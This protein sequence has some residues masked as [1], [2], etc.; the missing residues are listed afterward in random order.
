MT[1]VRRLRVG[2]S[3]AS[4]TG[5][6]VSTFYT[7]G[8]GAALNSAVNV[9]F[10]AIKS[11]FPTVT[12]WT[13]PTSGEELD[14]NTGNVTGVWTGGTPATL[15]GSG[16]PEHAQGVGGRIVW[17][18]GGITGGRLVRGSTF[19]VP[20]C[21]NQYETDGT[22]LNAAVTAFTTAGQA[23]VTTLAGDLVVLTRVTPAH[24]GTSHAVNTAEMSQTVA[25][26]KTRKR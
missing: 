3:G 13:I 2:W 20:L 7:L 10:T 6:G 21:V 25:W 14:D 15:N 8:T 11:S 23:M 16:V 5:P 22:I 12:T 4:V 24:S 1:T 19:L 18:T 9:F 17:K 26:L